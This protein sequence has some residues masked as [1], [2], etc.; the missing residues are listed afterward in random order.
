MSKTLRVALCATLPFV[1]FLGA[2]P[3]MAQSAQPTASTADGL[4][5]IVVTARRKQ[6]RVQTVPIAITALSQTDIQQAH[7]QQLRDLYK[8][9]PGLSISLTSSDPNSLY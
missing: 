7:I 2:Q 6:E 9:V 1:G 8:V 3:A 4:E 5:E